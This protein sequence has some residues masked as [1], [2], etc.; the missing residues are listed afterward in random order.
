MTNEVDDSPELRFSCRKI[1]VSL[2][3]TNEVDELS[4]TRE[5]LGGNVARCFHPYNPI[6][7]LCSTSSLQE[8]KMCLLL[9]LLVV[10]KSRCAAAP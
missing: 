1:V 4:P 2:S 5:S 7:L 6:L 9:L 3:M 10:V 8:A